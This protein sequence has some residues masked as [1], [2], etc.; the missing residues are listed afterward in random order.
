MERTHGRGIRTVVLQSGDDFSFSRQKV[1]RLIKKIKAA[2]PDMAVT[3]SLGERPF[4]DY[5]AFR[6]S[7]ADRYLLK[8]ETANETLYRFLH[9][10][11]SLG[12]RLRIQEFLRGLGF[13]IGSGNIVGLPGQTL[14]DLADDILFYQRQ[15]PD[16]IGIGPFMPQSHTPLAEV[17]SPAIDLVMRMIA[18]TRLVTGNAH[19]PITTAL[20]TLGGEAA[21][22][23]GLRAGCN[24]MM[25]NFTPENFRKD[26]LIYDNKTE[27]TL[28]RARR[29]SRQANRSISLVRG[30]SLKKSVSKIRN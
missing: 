9:P 14:S 19:M 10:G 22:A 28:A 29:V 15:Q 16:M 23:Q 6:D 12:Q 5:R 7:G 20:A 26:Y 18:L 4:G 24:V 25:L 1:C 13:Q 8:H 3:L 2:Y 30:D 27:V 21:Q 17:P 11:Q